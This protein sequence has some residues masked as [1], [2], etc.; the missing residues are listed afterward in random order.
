MKGCRVLSGYPSRL[1]AQNG[2]ETSSR[3]VES[4]ACI[5]RF[6]P[7]ETSN[8]SLMPSIIWDCA[9]PGGYA[10][11]SFLHYCLGLWAGGAPPALPE[12]R[13]SL[14]QSSSRFLL[15]KCLHLVSFLKVFPAIEAHATFTPFTHLVYIFLHVLQRVELARVY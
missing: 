14:I 8:K 12:A 4:D 13:L 11:I 6:A 2:V 5:S 9:Q 3:L 15:L 1:R 7:D 10:R